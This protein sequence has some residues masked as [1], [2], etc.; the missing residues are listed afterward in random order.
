MLSTIS[1]TSVLSQTKPLAHTP[2]I[3]AQ[4]SSLKMEAPVNVT[5][6]PG[7]IDELTAKKV[8][9]YYCYLRI[10]I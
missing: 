5:R 3:L 2:Q 6:I 10:K 1:F 8:L 4:F 7:C 9:A